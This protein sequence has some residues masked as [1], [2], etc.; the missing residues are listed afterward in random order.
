MALGALGR[1]SMKT[2]PVEAVSQPKSAGETS[3]PILTLS[4]TM[5]PWHVLP[6]AY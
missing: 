2:F 4:C 3:D 6:S 1:A 5:S